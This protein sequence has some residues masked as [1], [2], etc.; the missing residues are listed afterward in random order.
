M[1]AQSA[2]LADKPLICLWQHRQEVDI[3][4]LVKDLGFNTVWTDDEPYRGQTWE[5]THMYRALQVA[6]VEYVIPK[7]ERIQWGQTH[8]GSVKHA[9]W[10]AELSP[11][12][13][14]IVGL[15]LNDFYDEIEDGYRT[16]EQ[17]RE[18]ISAAKDVNPNLSIIVPHYPHRGNQNRPYD[19]DHD[20]IVFNVWHHDDVATAEAHL[21]QAERQHPGVPIITGLYL[22]SGSD[23]GHWLAEQEFK[24]MLGLFVDHLN[25]GKTAG[26]RIFCACQLEQRPEYVDWAKGVL[27]GLRAQG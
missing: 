19:F 17:W 1:S 25:A 4:P 10:V 3:A 27:K 15:Y 6:G 5:D 21:V 8:E 22:N 26:M 14:E 13:R 23:G 18:I 9:R 24:T 2:A 7:V 16:M 11:S 20:A 12:H